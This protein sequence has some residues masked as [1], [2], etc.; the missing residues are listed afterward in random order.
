SER[1]A[2]RFLSGFWLAFMASRLTAAFLLPSGRETITLLVLA[3]A[4]LAVLLAIVASRGAMTAPA[5]V[6]A[7]G[8]VFRPILPIIMALLVGH[9]PATLHGRAVGLLFA[10]AGIGWTTIPILIG[11]SARRAGVQRG[12]AIAAGA[13]AGLT[14]IALLFTL[15]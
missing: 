13:A 9:S 1:T 15:R 12:F 5:L 4:S 8:V 10:L 6:L 14:G 3:A 11:A 7:A 2:P